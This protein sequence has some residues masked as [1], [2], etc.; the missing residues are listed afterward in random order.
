MPEEEPFTLVREFAEATFEVLP[1][2]FPWLEEFCALD[3]PKPP[4]M[5]N[6]FPA[7][8][9]AFELPCAFPNELISDDN[10]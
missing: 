6:G 10:I 1:P 2:W 4:K 5:L 8:A 9:F 7:L 3:R